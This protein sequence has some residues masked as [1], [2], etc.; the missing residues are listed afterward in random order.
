M[1]FLG[2]GGYVAFDLPRVVA[3]LGAALLLGIAATHAYLLGGREPLPRYFVVYAA[4]VIAGCLLAAGGIEFGRNPRVA[5]AGWLLGS[6]LSV[7][8]L[9][10]DVGTRWASVPS[11]TTMTG[12]WDFAPATCVL[13]CAGAFLGVHASVLLGI[14]VAYP[15]RRHWED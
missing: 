9:G 6:L 12:R 11:L 14:N 4:A 8:I 10:V 7:V 15:Q 13:A 1:G 3:G 5:Q 2:L